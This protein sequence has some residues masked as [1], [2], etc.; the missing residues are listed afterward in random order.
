MPAK[1]RATGS[2]ETAGDKHQA[3]SPVVVGPVFELDRR[4]G[5]VLDDMNND[6]PAALGEGQEA[7]DA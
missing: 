5:H 4:V 7:F 6:R 3:R 1:S 2:R